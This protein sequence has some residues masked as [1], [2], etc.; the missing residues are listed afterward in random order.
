[1]HDID[2]SYPPSAT[3]AAQSSPNPWQVFAERAR[4]ELETWAQSRPR[5]RHRAER[6][7]ALT[8]SRSDA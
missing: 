5:E 3:D 7:A 8:Q 4:R 6:A 1:M 2:E